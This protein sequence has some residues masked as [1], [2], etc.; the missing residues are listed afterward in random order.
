MD[1]AWRTSALL[2]WF[3][4]V[5]DRHVSRNVNVIQEKASI[6]KGWNWKTVIEFHS[7]YNYAAHV[8]TCTANICRWHLWEDKRW[9]TK[10]YWPL[11]VS[12]QTA[13][14]SRSWMVLQRRLTSRAMSLDDFE[15]LASTERQSS[16]RI[17]W[18]TWSST[19]KIGTMATIE[20]GTIVPIGFTM[21]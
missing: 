19:T 17:R 2:K 13:L 16:V 10:K 9:P 15:L 11:F 5:R 1:T 21:T 4:H 12:G 14:F 6:P 7:F 8:S 3:Q 20:E 18:K